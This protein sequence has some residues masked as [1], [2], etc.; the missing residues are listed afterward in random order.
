MQPDI[1]PTQPF[2]D[3]FEQSFRDR[4]H[5]LIELGYKKARSKFNSITEETEITSHIYEAIQDIIE[6]PRSTFDWTNFEVSE[7]AKV[8]K[9]SVYGKFKPRIDIIVI[10]LGIRGL[11]PK[12]L[13]EAK[14]LRASGYPVSKYIGSEGVQCF[15]TGLYAKEFPEAAMLGYIQSNSIILWK[16]K[17]KKAIDKNAKILELQEPQQ[18][19]NGLNAFPEEWFSLHTRSSVG[20]PLKIY[21]ILLD[22]V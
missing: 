13:F 11:R 3:E 17:I 1:Q 15:T 10:L 19:Y 20:R 12:Y 6:D 16:T 8:R 22:C 18:N 5:F 4:V 14:R 21:H 2:L 7:D 9:P